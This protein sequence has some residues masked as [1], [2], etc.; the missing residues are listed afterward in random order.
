MT[1]PFV[2]VSPGIKQRRVQPVDTCWPQPESAQPSG[3]QVQ[4]VGNAVSVLW[5]QQGALRLAVRGA[6]WLSVDSLTFQREFSVL[7]NPSP[8]TWFGAPGCRIE[9]QISVPKDWGNR[10]PP[11]LADPFCV[12][13]ALPL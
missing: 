12:E 3:S 13:V 9:P 1:G 4:H 2:R 8:K 7:S 11:T 10:G 5:R 6:V